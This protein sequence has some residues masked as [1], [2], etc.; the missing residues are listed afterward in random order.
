MDMFLW[1]WPCDLAKMADANLRGPP[2]SW[3]CLHITASNASKSDMVII[4][5]EVIRVDMPK[6]VVEIILY[7]WRKKLKSYS[8]PYMGHWV[9]M[10]QKMFKSQCPICGTFCFPALILCLMYILVICYVCLIT[11]KNTPASSINCNSNQEP[12]LT[13]VSSI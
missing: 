13:L 12:Y 5:K 8:V 7:C 2:G 3:V 9:S 10:R 4:T 1:E 11:T 6:A